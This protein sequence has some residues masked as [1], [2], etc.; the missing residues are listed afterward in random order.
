MYGN[1]Y[2]VILNVSYNSNLT[3]KLI[4]V[5]IKKVMLRTSANDVLHEPN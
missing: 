5:K 1:I 2:S 3:L 4:L